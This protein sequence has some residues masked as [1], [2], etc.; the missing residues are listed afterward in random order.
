MEKVPGYDCPHGHIL[1]GKCLLCER[2]AQ[3]KA[4]AVTA[5]TAVTTDDQLSL[6][7]RQRDALLAVVKAVHYQ[8]YSA[9]PTYRVISALIESVESTP[10][11]AAHVALIAAAPDLLAA[12]KALDDCYSE[13]SRENL[14]RAEMQHHKN[15]RADVADIIAKAEGGAA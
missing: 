12:L 4:P 15:V 8:D 7:T 5:V 6:V 3:N 9:L 1:Y 10:P 13:T 11:F 2:E 14:T